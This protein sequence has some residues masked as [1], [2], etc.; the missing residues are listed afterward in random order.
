MSLADS[1]VVFFVALSVF[2]V[3]LN[4]RDKGTRCFVDNDIENGLLK[5]EAN[6]KP[7]P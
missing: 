3:T 1:A 6:E 7:I 5:P 4:V 2:S